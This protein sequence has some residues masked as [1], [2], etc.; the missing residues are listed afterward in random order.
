MKQIL[1]T[2]LISTVA[3]TANAQKKAVSHSKAAPKKMTALVKATPLTLKNNVDSASYAFGHIMA[4]NLKMSGVSALNYELMVKGLQDAFTN[5][6]AIIDADQ[7]QSA[8]N[9]IFQDASKKQYEASIAAGKVF[10]ENNKKVAGVITTASG[11][12]YQVLKAGTGEKP[13]ATSKVTVHYK[14]NLMDGK[15]FDSSYDRGTPTSFEVDKVIPGWTEGLQLM[16]KGAKYK[17]FV[18]FDLAYGERAPGPE[19]PAYSNLIF[20]IELLEIEGK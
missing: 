7:S 9:N 11:L 16:Q 4:T 15:L 10:F 18:P 6:I 13:I 17:F 5:K 1:I 2:C 14:G 12:Q 20:E 19:I 3:F 8:I